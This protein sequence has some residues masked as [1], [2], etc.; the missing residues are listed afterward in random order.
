MLATFGSL[1]VVPWILFA[2]SSW[3]MDAVPVITVA[4]PREAS[5]TAAVQDRGEVFGHEAEQRARDALR[6][7]HRGHRA[8]VLVE[9]VRSLDG[10]WIADVARRRSEMSGADGLYIL[11]AGH[12]REVGVIGAR[13]G[14]ASRLTDQQREAIR[15]AFLGPLQAGEP[16]EALDRGVR[17]IE[18]TLRA[19]EAGQ[20][21]S[22][23]DALL[24]VAVLLASLAVLLASKTWARGRRSGRHSGVR[25]GLSRRRHEGYA[26]RALAGPRSLA[27]TAGLDG[28]RRILLVDPV[29]P[30][31]E[32]QPSA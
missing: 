8:R 27:F 24:S 15:R 2:Q 25:P 18:A 5:A 10:A 29:R 19:A 6:R 22:P 28:R 12:E 13:R 9:T 31:E 17:A 7:A 4:Q 1:S 3:N 14:P 23:R 21:S 32:P 11:V 30:P 26:R 20:R 16:D